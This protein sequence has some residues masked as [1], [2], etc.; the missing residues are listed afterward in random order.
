MQRW[1][2]S[3]NTFLAGVAPSQWS[4]RIDVVVMQ[5][6]SAFRSHDPFKLAGCAFH[7]F[8]V[9]HGTSGVAATIR[10]I[11]STDARVAI[12]NACG[13]SGRP[14]ASLFSSR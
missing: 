6:A 3:A 7:V 5:L 2:S 13:L 11:Q 14:V 1:A 9:S 4:A 8:N 12:S 10:R